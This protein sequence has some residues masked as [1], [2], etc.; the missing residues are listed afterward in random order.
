MRNVGSVLKLVK[1]PVYRSP[2]Y[3]SS[4]SVDDGAKIA[5]KFDT[6]VK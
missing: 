1:F 4:F 6:I 3:R 5:N 2:V